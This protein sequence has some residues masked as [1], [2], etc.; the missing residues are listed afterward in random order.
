[1]CAFLLSLIYLISIYKHL[2]YFQV[3]M[4]NNKQY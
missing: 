3:K 2:D 4:I 1:M